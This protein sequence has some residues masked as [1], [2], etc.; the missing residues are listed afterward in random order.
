MGAP[1][2]HPTGIP[3][4]D[5][6]LGWALVDL[7]V[8]TTHKGQGDMRQESSSGTGTKGC[9]RASLHLAVQGGITAVVPLA[10]G[11]PSAVAEGGL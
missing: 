10:R 5:L 1:C 7:N 8:L 11:G 9:G 3:L 4:A 2:S 6:G